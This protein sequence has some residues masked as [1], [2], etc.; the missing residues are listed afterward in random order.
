MFLITFTELKISVLRKM[1]YKTSQAF[2]L[3]NK[4]CITIHVYQNEFVQYWYQKTLRGNPEIELDPSHNGENQIQK[5]KE[6]VS[7]TKVK[8]TQ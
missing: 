5:I 1:L 7:N 8:Q 4:N 3:Y 6:K 2:H